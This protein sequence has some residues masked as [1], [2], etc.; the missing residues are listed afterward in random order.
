MQ[1]D[2]KLK[3]EPKSSDSPYASP[4]ADAVERGASTFSLATLMVVIALCAIGFGIAYYTLGLGFAFFIIAMLAFARVKLH[5]HTGWEVGWGVSV[6]S[7]A[8][9]L[10]ILP[11]CCGVAFVTNC[12]AGVAAIEQLPFLT[13][14][15]QGWFAILVGGITALQVAELVFAFCLRKR[16]HETTT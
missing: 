3:H 16:V 6:G 8:I 2:S 11:I 10:F 7:L 5:H 1:Q 15:N 13:V 9:I 12:V 4:Q 14:H